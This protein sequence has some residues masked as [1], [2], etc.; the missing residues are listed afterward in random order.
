MS[1]LE[2][3]KHLDVRLR[4]ELKHPIQSKMAKTAQ[5]VEKSIDS[6]GFLATGN[7]QADIEAAIAK[8]NL[9]KVSNITTKSLRTLS[10]AGLSYFNDMSDAVNKI[11]L[12]LDE[13]FRRGKSSLYRALL[14]GYLRIADQQVP[15]GTRG[16][17]R[18][19]QVTGCFEIQ[20]QAL[21][22]KPNWRIILQTGF[23]AVELVGI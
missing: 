1:I 14:N 16:S 10:I 2:Q 21:I 5:Q 4:F 13:V 18:P 22:G 20:L 8:I 11:K 23:P 6:V 12:L 7:P 9:G 15:W 17:D 19:G 3:L